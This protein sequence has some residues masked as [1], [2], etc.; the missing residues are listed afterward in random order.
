MAASKK[1]KQSRVAAL[2]DSDNRSV[3][4]VIVGGL[5][6]LFV[7]LGLSIFDVAWQGHDFGALNYGGGVIAIL[8]AIGGSKRLRDGLSK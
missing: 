3:D 4:S 2:F 8:G 1:P 5:A 7:Y 6:S